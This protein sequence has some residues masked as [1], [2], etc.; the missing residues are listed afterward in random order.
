MENI[1]C[2]L[3]R[4]GSMSTCLSDTINGFNAFVL[5]QP[6]DTQVTTLLFNN[7]IQELYRCKN[8]RDIKPLDMVTYRPVG[9]TALLDVIGYT[10]SLASNCTTDNNTIVIFTDGEENVS[11]TYT[12]DDIQAL[13]HQ[14]TLLG[15]KFV[16]MGANQ[17]AIRVASELNINSKS[18]L[19]F[20]TTCVKGAF[21][22]LSNAVNR[23]RTGENHGIEFSAEERRS[24]CPAKSTE[25]EM[26]TSIRDRNWG[27]AGV[28]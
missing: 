20:S 15:W 23:F 4:S 18:A 11:V 5:D 19:T 21:E 16:F 24:S 28:W 3:D 10:V 7:T 17:D 13:I 25:G 9:C 27:Y 2:I 12:K 6:P 14:K 8:P 1:F 22:C 26:I